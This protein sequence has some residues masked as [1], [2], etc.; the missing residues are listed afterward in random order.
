M[1]ERWFSLKVDD[2]VL[3]KMTRAE[4]YA[5]RRWLRHAARVIQFMLPPY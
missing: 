2:A 1:G 3:R 5:T 4:Y